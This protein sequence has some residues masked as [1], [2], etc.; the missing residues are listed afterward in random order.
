MVKYVLKP[1]A[2]KSAKV[3]GRALRISRKSSV[4]V[5]SKISRM[6]RIRARDFFKIL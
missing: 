3:Y 5:C 1:R 2:S 4:I 6:R